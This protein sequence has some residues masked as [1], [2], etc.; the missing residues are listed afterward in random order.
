MPS[1]DEIEAFEAACRRWEDEEHRFLALAARGERAAKD[2]PEEQRLHVAALLETGR[3][4]LRESKGWLSAF[5]A[6]LD[7]EASS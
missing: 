3:R 6:T 7:A 5:V 1:R 4:Q 2:A